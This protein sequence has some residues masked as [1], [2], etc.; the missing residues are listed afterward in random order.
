[1][2]QSPPSR[3]RGLKLYVWTFRDAVIMVASFSEAWIEM[4]KI[5]TTCL[6]TRWS[7]PSRRRGLKWL[8]TISTTVSTGRLLLGGVDWNKE[9]GEPMFT[10]TGRLLLGGV[11]W[12]FHDQSHVNSTVSPPSRRRGLKSSVSMQSQPPKSSPPS[13]RRGLK[14]ILIHLSALLIVSPPSRRR[15]LK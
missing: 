6:K 3:R 7:P 13:R 2:L 10:L 8:S 5:L 15:G 1:M 4:G 14:S 9:D 12:N 11:D